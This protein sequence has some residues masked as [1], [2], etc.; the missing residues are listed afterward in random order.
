MLYNDGE[1]Y[2]AGGRGCGQDDYAAIY[3]HSCLRVGHGVDDLPAF[4]ERVGFFAGTAA[5]NDQ[6]GCD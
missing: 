1:E 3:S 6:G 2:R 5:G 4:G